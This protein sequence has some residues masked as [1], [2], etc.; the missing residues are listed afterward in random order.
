MTA[1]YSGALSWLARLQSVQ[2]SFEFPALCV[3]LIEWRAKGSEGRA[4]ILWMGYLR[5]VSNIQR[6]QLNSMN[7]DSDSEFQPL[8]FIRTTRSVKLTKLIQVVCHI[9][10]GYFA[11]CLASINSRFGSLNGFLGIDPIRFTR[12]RQ[13][14]RPGDLE[15]WI[16]NEFVNGLFIFS[17]WLMLVESTQTL[18]RALFCFTR[19]V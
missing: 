11:I 19:K 15:F 18:N 8:S 17:F 4:Q 2:P 7:S 13:V 10:R 9:W 12:A 16:Q 3:H 14:H 1:V 6:M 5:Q